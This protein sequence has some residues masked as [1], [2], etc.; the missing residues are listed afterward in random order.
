MCDQMDQD[1]LT[2]RAG[3]RQIEI[4]VLQLVWLDCF[5]S[6]YFSKDVFVLCG[7]FVS[8]MHFKSTLTQLRKL[9]IM[10]WT[11][12]WT[13]RVDRSPLMRSTT[14]QCQPD[15]KVK[16]EEIKSQVEQ[17]L[18][19]IQSKEHLHFFLLSSIRSWIS[20]QSPKKQ[21]YPWKILH[22][23]EGLLLS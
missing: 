20:A 18:N 17:A 4:C 1:Y 7:G 16:W 2:H 8:Q 6:L 5:S 21:M 22:Q 10:V 15:L 19:Q 14:W 13:A 23:K 3:Y 12:P 9:N 11:S